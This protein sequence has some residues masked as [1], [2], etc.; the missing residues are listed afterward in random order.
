M[1]VIIFITGMFEEDRFIESKEKKVT[2]QS[3][4]SVAL[5]TLL[6]LIYRGHLYLN[7]DIMYT[8]LAGADHLLYSEAKSLCADFMD[9]VLD[10]YTVSLTHAFQIRMA[11][12][13]YSVSWLQSKAD[14]IISQSFSDMTHSVGFLELNCEQLLDLLSRDDIEEEDESVFWRAGKFTLYF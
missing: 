10:H 5:S 6:D 7:T 2:L 3:I 11:A 9:H 4:S 8:V 14:I 1:N 12:Q 13:L